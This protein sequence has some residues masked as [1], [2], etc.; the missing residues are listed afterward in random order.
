[1]KMDVHNVSRSLMI[2]RNYLVDFRRGVSLATLCSLVDNVFASV[3]SFSRSFD[4]KYCVDR[5]T[6][7]TRMKYLTYNYD[8]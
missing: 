8:M 1:M 5:V 3:S 6:E 4:W 2:I 7:E